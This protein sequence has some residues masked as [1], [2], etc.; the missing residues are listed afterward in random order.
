MVNEL[1]RELCTTYC[2]IR[3]DY[4]QCEAR[5]LIHDLVMTGLRLEGIALEDREDAARIAEAIAYDEDS[6]EQ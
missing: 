1:L 4:P 6:T 2:T 3:A 5:S